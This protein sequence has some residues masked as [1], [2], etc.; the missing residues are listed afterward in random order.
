[1]ASKGPREKIMMQSTG[2][3][4]DGKPT[5]YSKTTIKNK[6]NT[7][8]KLELVMFDPVAYNEKTGRCGMRIAFKEKKVPK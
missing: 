2:K 7:P 5:K 6:R 8:D 3:R 4:K 1:M